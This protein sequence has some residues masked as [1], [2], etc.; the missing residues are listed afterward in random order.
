MYSEED[1]QNMANCDL[2]TCMGEYLDR[3][4][5]FPLL[6]FLSVK[7]VSPEPY[8]FVK[9]MNLHYR[10]MCIFSLHSPG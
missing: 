1:R 10:S 2:T 3:H 9:I 6:E 7:E 5:V 4:L 8:S